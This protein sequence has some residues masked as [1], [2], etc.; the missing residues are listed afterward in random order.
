MLFYKLG[1]TTL[2]VKQSIAV[3]I[4]SGSILRISADLV[5]LNG[6][7]DVEWDGETVQMFAVDI[8]ERG[9]LIQA[10]Q[11]AKQAAPDLASDSD[12]AIA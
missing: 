12:R 10:A 7:V 11:T 3:P 9:T 2:A 6:L 5:D 4:P 1:T 8:R